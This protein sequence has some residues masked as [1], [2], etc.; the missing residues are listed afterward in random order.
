LIR[1]QALVEIWWKDKLARRLPVLGSD[2]AHL[3]RTLVNERQNERLY[4]LYR[5]RVARSRDFL[6]AVGQLNGL[7][8]AKVDEVVLAGQRGHLARVPTVFLASELARGLN[9]LGVE[10]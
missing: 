9:D 4:L 10:L 1:L 6:L 5:N 8:Q 3:L 2:T 7:S